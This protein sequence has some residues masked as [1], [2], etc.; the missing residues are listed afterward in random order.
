MGEVDEIRET[1]LVEEG[2][3]D[4]IRKPIDPGLLLARV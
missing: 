2:A 3:A 4:C 1:Q